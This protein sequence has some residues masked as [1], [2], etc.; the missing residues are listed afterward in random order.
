M[1]GRVFVPEKTLE[2]WASQYITHRY[3]SKASLWWPVRGQDIDVGSLPARPGKG[4]QIEMKTAT[5]SRLNTYEV[6]I[7]LGQL[8]DYKS[9]PLALQPF[10]VFPLPPS[11]LHWHG[12]LSTVAS[13]SRQAVTELAFARSGRGLWFADWLVVLPTADVASLLSSALSRH[14]SPKRGT[15]ARLVQFNGCKPRQVHWGVTGGNPYP[16]ITPWLDFWRSLEACGGPAW[17]QFVRVPRRL[18]PAPPRGI[19]RREMAEALGRSN[20]DKNGTTHESEDF[21]TLAPDADDQWTVMELPH[22]DVDQALDLQD[23][24]GLEDRRQIVFLDAGALNRV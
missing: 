9:R 3:S 11:C 5:M 23:N 20:S 15:K 6:L 4:I 7:D 12:D 18:L 17:P 21:V 8:F 14:G 10:Y 22:T 24:D 1:A 13:R 2:H 16:A 19:T